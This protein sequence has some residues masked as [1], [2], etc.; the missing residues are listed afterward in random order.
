MSEMDL[1]EHR[2]MESACG[3]F[4]KNKEYKFKK[5]NKNRRFKIYLSKRTRLSLFS[6]LHSLWRF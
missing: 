6:T 2:F 3:P 4:T 5:K 1:R